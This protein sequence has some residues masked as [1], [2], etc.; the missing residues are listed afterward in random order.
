MRWKALLL[1]LTCLSVG[2]GILGCAGSK[3]VLDPGDRSSGDFIWGVIHYGYENRDLGKAL[4]Y[5]D[6]ALEVHGAEARRLQASLSD[7]PA[8]DP[9]EV[10]YRYNNLNNIAM[11]M[12]VKGDL[13]LEKGDR[14]GAEAAY[15]MV[16]QEFGYAQVQDL[17]GYQ[18]D[19]PRDAQGFIKV[20][21]AAKQRLATMK[22]SKD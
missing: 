14:E 10:A 7:F 2:L 18:H 5:A 22:G 16:I 13:L 3:P 4:L 21:D 17:E 19:L 12:L 6:R 15:S 11:A 1:G 20:A 8:T 9:P